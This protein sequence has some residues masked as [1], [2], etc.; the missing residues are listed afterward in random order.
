MKVAF[1]FPS[2][3]YL[4]LLGCRGLLSLQAP[5][6]TIRHHQIQNDMRRTF[7]LLFAFSC[8]SLFGQVDST[9]Q[10]ISTRGEIFTTRK[11]PITLPLPNED[12][13]FHFVI[14]GDR[15]GGDPSGLKVLRQAVVDTNLI[16]PDFVLTV[17]D[18][19]QGY[20]RPDQ[21]MPQ[22]REFTGIMSDL[23]M[24][25]FPVAGNHDIYWDF[26]DRNRPPMHHEANY[27]KHFG[28]LWYSFEHKDC[29]FIV[30]FSD[31]GNPDTGEKGF[32]DA[33]LQN[34]S[35]EQMKFLEQALERHGKCR[36][37]FVFLHHPRW[38]GGGYEG[39][40]WPV[41]HQRLKNAGNV[42]GVFAGHI[43]HMT[44]DG[45]VDGIEYFTLA[46]T[47]GHLGLD[48]PELGHLHHFNIVTVRDDKFT[49]AT[50]PVGGVID[51][52]TFKK[53]FLEDVERV[54]NLRP[55]RAGERLTID[56]NSASRGEYS[57]KIENPGQRP[58]EVTVS[59]K[60][61]GKWQAIPDHQHV[62]IPPGKSEGMRFS[63]YRASNTDLGWSEFAMPQFAMNVDY[64]HSKARIRLPEVMVPIDLGLSF[65]DDF[66]SPANNKCLALRGIQSRSQRRPLFSFPNDSARIQSSDVNLPDGPFTL[67]AWIN[68][69]DI[70]G[71]RGIVAKT[72]SSEYALFLHDG[73][74]Q[75]DVHLDGK[76]VSP[77]T[78]ATVTLNRWTHVAGVFDGQQAS[79]YID[80]KLTK[81][82]PATGKRDT[83]NLP[84]FIGAD[85]D[86]FG[87]PTREFAGRI[88]E[89]R[90]SVGA[91]YNGNFEPALRF[92]RDN[93]SL[94]LLHL[95]QNF[96]PFLLNDV[97]QESTVFKSGR[98]SIV[99]RNK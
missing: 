61:D 4:H 81:S 16:D 32:R 40:N 59:T 86:G 43:H 71:S 55:S 33:R 18:L 73:R 21:W 34:V 95:D 89:V 93:D 51:P 80:G 15:T 17:G 72:Q 28:P 6:E 91:K 68:P 31:E 52:K 66:S 97:E 11:N 58:I 50:I 96:G 36:Q 94:V 76:Y 22:M 99:S 45:P 27:E 10:I 54:R 82:L 3:Q 24:N 57:I 1:R 70:S 83:N 92:E 44:Y 77:S 75:F 74:P 29:G 62:V 42:K 48:S 35:P 84:L 41:V 79:L 38:L 30:L 14:Y 88:D 69:T 7:F 98:S 60:L 9:K 19:I 47:G 23:K 13:A 37:V 39:S 49:V 12:D 63:F 8:C 64:L 25:W 26:R 46:T 20:N 90:L 2:V 78:D 85:P 65:S 56:E 53:D 5:F 87:N 67:E